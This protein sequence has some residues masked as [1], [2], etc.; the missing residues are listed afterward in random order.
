M[1]SPL[2]IGIVGCSGHYGYVLGALPELVGVAELCA[3]APGC[4]E[5]SLA[6]LQNACREARVSP[7]VY[8][9]SEAMFADAELDIVAVNPFYALHAPVC[10]AALAR[11]IAPFCEKPLALSLEDLAALRAAH[12]AAGVPLGMMLDMRYEPRFATAQR[13]VASGVIG[14]PIVGYAQKSYKF[15][16]R[17]DFYKRR[18]TFGGLIPWVGIHA[19]DWFRWVSGRR[20][21]AVTATHANLRTPDYPELEDHATCLFELDNGGSA[22]MSFDYLRP[23]SAAGHGDDRLRLV[24]SEGILEI[25]GTTFEV[26]TTGGLHPVT[27]A[28]PPFG[29]FADFVRAV[30][31][32]TH[33]PRI[34]AED[35]FRTT[36]IALQARE[37]ADRG[38]RIEL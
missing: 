12:A 10:R 24:G 17:P 8:E 27:P 33:V 3:V 28:R 9:T 36:Q 26:R 30:R 14:E 2:R 34:T 18:A 35:A 7:Q 5:E 13:L 23:A 6:P 16:T 19:I 21:T 15:G 29:L 38:M 22:V 37:A 1:S 4:A 31:D 20:Y 11:G 32:E 25:Q